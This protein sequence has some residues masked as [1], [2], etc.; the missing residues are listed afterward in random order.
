MKKLPRREMLKIG[1]MAGL[2]GIASFYG[3]T[4]LTGCDIGGIGEEGD[5][6]KP[7]LKLGYLPITDHLLLISLARNK[8]AKANIKPVQY[9]GWPELVE[10]IRAGAVDAGFLLTPLGLELRHNKVPVKA[11]LLGHRNGS[12]I[13]VNPEANI[14]RVEELAGK[15]V[16][17]P[18]R[19]STHNI[20]LNKSLQQHGIDTDQ[21]ESIEM[22][23]PEMVQ[24]LNAGQIDAFI[25]AEPFGG[26][27]EKQGV[28]EVLLLSKE[29][30][31]NH[32]C[33]VLNVREEALEDKPEAVEEL[34][35]SLVDTG[36][37][38]ENNPTEA[39]GLSPEFLGQQPST[40]EHVLT[41][42]SE[43]VTFDDLQLEREDFM[44]TKE[45]L[46]TFNIQQLNV[47]MEEYLENSFASKAYEK[48]AHARF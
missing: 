28:G 9:S 14:N 34:V 33:C 22:A 47:D 40:I 23:P 7:T 2:W 15:R 12:M 24:A 26:Q 44:A 42:P 46:D 32:I 6:D 27:A 19:Y 21:V 39:A 20:L 11:I 4:V 31:S 16:A 25:V 18:S 45:Y 5:P 48:L 29:I 38:I 1:G 37:F 8:F 17:I 10:A 3:L 43:R 13:T 41:S 36:N 30:W 35:E